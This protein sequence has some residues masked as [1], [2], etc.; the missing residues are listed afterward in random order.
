MKN[1]YI[2]GIGSVSIQT[3]EYSV[4]DAAPEKVQHLNHAQQ[5]SYKELIAPAMSRRMARGI[6]MSIYAANQAMN[7]AENPD[8]DAIIAGTSL[9]CIEDSEK[10]LNTI[11]E[12]DEEF[13]TP[14][15]FIQSTHNTVAAQI[16]LQLQCK[17][18][19]FTYV[20][21]GNSFESAL[22]SEEH[23]SELQSR[24]HLVCRLLLEKK[25]KKN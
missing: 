23:T 13:L 4:F 3:P 17:S 14:T 12:N 21:G 7:E 22:R 11:I 9:G 2:N 8:L 24:P 5:P 25:K 15:A 10:F 19:N 6:K 1:C 16:A 18:F 20:N